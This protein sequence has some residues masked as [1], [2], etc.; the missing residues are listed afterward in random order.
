MLKLL[1]SALLVL[2]VFWS[3]GFW[4]ASSWAGSVAPTIT[5]APVH[6]NSLDSIVATLSVPNC[7]S[8]T[9]VV[10]AAAQINITTGEAGGCGVPPPI[11][12]A[13]VGYLPAG[14]YQVQW[15]TF[16]GGQIPVA[17]ATLAVTLGVPATPVVPTPVLDMWAKVLCAL[18]LA[19]LADRSL[20]K[21]RSS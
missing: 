16:S 10:V 2:A 13:T 18:G 4:S 19:A 12:V 20:C 9:T 1:R 3:A 6:P 8:A 17:T 21:R 5:F 15:F 11:T 14:I 7:G